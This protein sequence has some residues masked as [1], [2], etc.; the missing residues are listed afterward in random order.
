MYHADD[1]PYLGTLA[2]IELDLAVAG[3]VLADSLGYAKSARRALL[4]V[5]ERAS[6]YVHG[7]NA[8][9]ARRRGR[10]R[11]DA[12]D[13]TIVA[14]LL[15]LAVTIV[16]A[17]VVARALH[18]PEPDD[19]ASWRSW[20]SSTSGPWDHPEDHKGAYISPEGHWCEPT[21]PNSP[22]S[23]YNCSLVVPAG[24][25]TLP[26]IPDQRRTVKTE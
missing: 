17:L 3:G 25:P 21:L 13:S 14:V 6:A 22:L 24:I 11:R 20:S 5:R 2:R 8:I 19:G 15:M 7:L 1:C 26:G 23:G 10:E 9:V 12:G 16:L 18:S 4:V